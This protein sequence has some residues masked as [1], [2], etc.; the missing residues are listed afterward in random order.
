MKTSSPAKKCLLIGLLASALAAAWLFLRESSPLDLYIMPYCPYAQKAL[1]T[2]LP[3]LKAAGQ[4]NRLKIH[5]LALDAKFKRP[6]DTRSGYPVENAGCSL[7]G[8][9]DETGKQEGRFSSLHGQGE[10]EEAMRQAAIAKRWPGKF[11]PYLEAFAQNQKDWRQNCA[12]LGI[13]VDELAALVKTDEAKE[14]FAENIADAR[15]RKIYKSPALFVNGREVKSIRKSAAA[16]R[17]ELCSL[18]VIK[19]GC[20]GVACKAATQCPQK[21]GYQAVCQKSRCVYRRAPA[22]ADAVTV[23]AILPFECNACK[24]IPVADLLAPWLDHLNIQNLDLETPLAQDILRACSV[25]EFPVLALPSGIAAF[26]WGNELAAKL[27][28]T[29]AGEW[30]LVSI[31]NTVIPFQIYGHIRRDVKGVHMDFSRSATGFLL[32]QAGFD[33]LAANDYWAALGKNPNDPQVW[34]NLGA[35]LY[36]QQKMRQSAAAMFGRALKIDHDYEPALRNMIRYHMEE[37]QNAEA[38]SFKDRLAWV[39]CRKGNWR[40]AAALFNETLKSEPLK[41]DARKG[42]AWALV[43]LDQPAEAIP[44]LLKCVDLRQ[45]V[46]TDLANLLAGAYFRAGQKSEALKWYRQAVQGVR[47]SQEA[48][49]NLAGLLREANDWNDLLT[50]A[51]TGI[52]HWPEQIDFYFERTGALWRLC[53]QQESIKALNALR[54]HPNAPSSRIDYELAWRSAER[55]ERDAFD[56]QAKQLFQALRQKPNPLLKQEMIRIS[57]TAVE[58]KL[59]RL[60]VDGFNLVLACEP[61]NI[62]AHRLLAACYEALGNGRKRDEHSQLA[63]EFGG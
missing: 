7:A 13:P 12:A 27:Q 19:S 32:H 26:P 11:L 2:L 5:Y 51:D 23:F 60:A 50:V 38:A 35:I 29:K 33:R 25:K 10:V 42:L 6:Q 55:G 37:R 28:A 14:W 39:L 4:Q 22:A 62:E 3:M 16:L 24:I 46:E 31:N 63:K 54:Q 15:K 20:D 47:P 34:N 56:R 49:L 17:H 61:S 30:Y 18:G 1:S 53:Q 8:R 9:P 36:D 58:L 48:A 21:P 45:P 52:R 41:Y 59:Y 40:E 43:R 57:K 44:H